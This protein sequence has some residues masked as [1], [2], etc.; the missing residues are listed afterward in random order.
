MWFTH[1]VSTLEEGRKTSRSN[2]GSVEITM[3]RRAPFVAAIRLTG[4]RLGKRQSRNYVISE[5]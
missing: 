4:G 2:E 1:L 3:S 5:L